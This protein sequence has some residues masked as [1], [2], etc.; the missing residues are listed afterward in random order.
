MRVLEHPEFVTDF[1]V[2]V[3]V[4]EDRLEQISMGIVLRILHL[5]L[6]G[7][8]D[9]G[10]DYVPKGLE[11]CAHSEYHVEEV[12]R[13]E[14]GVLLFLLLKLF[15]PYL[16]H[17]DL[18]LGVESLPHVDLDVL[19]V[20]EY[21]STEISLV[22]AVDLPDDPGNRVNLCHGF[23]VRQLGD[24]DDFANVANVDA[25]FFHDLAEVRAILNDE[26]QVVQFLHKP[27]NLL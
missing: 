4:I 26:I 1:D 21:L 16:L 27:H 11:L 12:D 2:D 10:P 22:V 6:I 5:E 19:V 20:P 8:F 13:V 24:F 3:A 9:L 18:R 15:D 25:I 17:A 14:F 23:D 7:L